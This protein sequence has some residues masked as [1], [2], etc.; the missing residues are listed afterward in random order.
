[1]ASRRGRNGVERVEVPAGAT[2]AR[3]DHWTS[4]AG[5]PHVHA[6]LLVHNR[7]R[8]DDG[9]WR[10]LD[11]R[12]IYRNAAAASMVGAAVLRAELSH[13]LGWAWDRVGDNWHAE[14]AGSPKP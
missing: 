6:H 11:G 9:K 13:R 4:R 7:V 12:L 10:T 8:C 3:F 1:M 2:I 5:D 14:L